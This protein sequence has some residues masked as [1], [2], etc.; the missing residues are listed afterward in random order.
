MDDEE[1]DASRLETGF[2]EEVVNHSEQHEIHF[3][4]ARNHV[5][6]SILHKQVGG[7]V[8]IVAEAGPQ[9]HLELEENVFLGE[10]VGA[11]SELRAVRCGELILVQGFEAGK[12][13]Q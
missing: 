2:K 3:S 8:C 6:R 5:G 4:A 9:K 12:V 11:T 1:V 10:H 7:T 13:H